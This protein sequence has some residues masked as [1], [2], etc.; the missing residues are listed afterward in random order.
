[1]ATRS[2]IEFNFRQALAQADKVDEIAD[3]LS[4]LSGRR[5]SGTMQNLAVNWKGESAAMYFSKGARLQDKMGDT[6]GELRRTADD[7]RRVARAL[8]EAEMAAL[9]IALRRDY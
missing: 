8:Y 4:N 6:V 2:G 3:R 7:I 1:M 9:E 5:F